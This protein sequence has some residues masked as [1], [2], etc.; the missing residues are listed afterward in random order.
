MVTVYNFRVWDQTLGAY[1]VQPLKSPAERI[2]Q[3]GGEIIEGTAEQVELSNLDKHERYDPWHDGIK[4]R[5]GAPQRPE[6]A[7][8]ATAKHT[9]LRKKQWPASKGRVR[10]GKSRA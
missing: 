4:M 5:P 8:K 10:K 7:V 2:K 9:P 1:V 3:I 6:V